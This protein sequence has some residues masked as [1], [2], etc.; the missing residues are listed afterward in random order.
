M[1][2]YEMTQ[3]AFNKQQENKLF[4]KECDVMP[5]LSLMFNSKQDAYLDNDIGHVFIYGGLMS[6]ASEMDE[7]MGNTEYSDIIEDINSM[8]EKGAKIIL[9]H[10]NSGGGEVT[11]STEVADVIMNCPI[12]IVSFL[13]G[14]ACSACYKLICGSTYIISSP[15]CMVGNIG[16]IMV[17]S[18]TSVFD[19]KMGLKYN[20]FVNDG[21]VYKSIGHDDSLT[22]DQI[23]YLQSNINQIGKDF[24]NH[25]T[26]NRYNIDPEVFKASWHY[27]IDAV[28]KGLVD[29]VGNE[30][31]AIS[32]CLE[33]I[34]LFNPEIVLSEIVTQD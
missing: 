10:V 18:D 15:S 33:L 2:I 23:D 9:I 26:S 32:I 20:V 14:C 24:E 12:P 27:G 6:D 7:L 31:D 5:D 11:G 8:I 22:T 28:N 25:V 34:K 19:N 30:K 17:F 21:A 1:K 16:S 29:T 3:D 4:I 13:E